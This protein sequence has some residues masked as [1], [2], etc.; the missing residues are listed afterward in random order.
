MYNIFVITTM[1][2]GRT[3]NGRKKTK[4]KQDNI[5]SRINFIQEQVT[6]WFTT[7]ETLGYDSVV[8]ALQGI[9]DHTS[10]AFKDLVACYTT[11]QA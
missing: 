1:Y 5:E 6:E 10:D 3:P 4:N 9:D 2:E 11:Q 7:Y 8:N